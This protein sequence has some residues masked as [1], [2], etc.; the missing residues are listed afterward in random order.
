MWCYLKN[1]RSYIAASVPHQLPRLVDLCWWPCQQSVK[2]A[3]VTMVIHQENL[4]AFSGSVVRPDAS[5]HS[6]SQLHLQSLCIEEP[7]ASST[8]PQEV[9][10]RHGHLAKRELVSWWYYNQWSNEGVCGRFKDCGHLHHGRKWQ[11]SQW[12]ESMTP[13]SLW[14]LVFAT[15]ASMRLTMS[16]KE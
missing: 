15:K 5:P 1:Q 10:N 14:S 2:A 12:N 16:C 6:P 3:R 13:P 7:K 11:L 8:R 9:G 4:F